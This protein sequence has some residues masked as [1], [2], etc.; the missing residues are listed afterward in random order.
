M[1]ESDWTWVLTWSPSFFIWACYPHLPSLCISLAI[2]HGPCKGKHMFCV[3]QE[4][5]WEDFCEW[6]KLLN[7][8]WSLTQRTLQTVRRLRW[9]LSVGAQARLVED[10]GSIWASSPSLLLRVL[11]SP[12]EGSSSGWGGYNDDD[13][14]DLHLFEIIK[15]KTVSSIIVPRKVYLCYSTFI[16]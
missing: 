3:A 11:V 9:G 15:N 16:L 7:P 10:L 5:T 2:A 1:R 6:L 14:S 12:R 4:D 13:D 8:F